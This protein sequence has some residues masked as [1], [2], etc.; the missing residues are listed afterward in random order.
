VSRTADRA[1]ALWGVIAGTVLVGVAVAVSGRG[2]DVLRGAVAPAVVAAVSWVAIRRAYYR[3]PETVWPLMVKAFPAKAV[4][5]VGYVVVVL[6]VLGADVVPFVSSF[7]VCFLATHL[8][9]AWCVR[10]LLMSGDAGGPPGR[11]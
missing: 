3:A 8:T 5:F 9:E 10:R 1:A 2:P 11:A 6:R 4:F 7:T